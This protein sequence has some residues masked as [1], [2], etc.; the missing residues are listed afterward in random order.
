[1]LTKNSLSYP[2][3]CMFL[4][5]YYGDNNIVFAKYGFEPNFRINLN[6]YQLKTMYSSEKS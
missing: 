1:M 3:G 2:Y 4:N 6:S 5:N